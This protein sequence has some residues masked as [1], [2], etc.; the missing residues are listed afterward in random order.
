MMN[1]LILKNKDEYKRQSLDKIT[2]Q[3]LVAFGVKYND[4][5]YFVLIKS[6]LTATLG[7]LSEAD[8]SKLIQVYGD[9]L[10]E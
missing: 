7:M 4:E 1:I 6:R 2:Q 8:L 5:K 10:V 3:H 9:G